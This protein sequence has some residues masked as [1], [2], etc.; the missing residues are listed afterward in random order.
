MIGLLAEVLLS[1]ILLR[2]LD[3]SSLEKLGLR[4]TGARMTDL[5]AGLMISALG[6]GLYFGLLVLFS[7]SDLALNS[8][9]KAASFFAGLWWT[10]KSVLFEEFLFRGALLFLAIKYLGQKAGC[11]LSAVAFGIYH[12]FSTR[13]SETSYK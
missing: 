12:W 5:L 1:W 6:S 4:P 10:T 13:Y 2:L 3:K 9:F 7:G 8:N 11:A